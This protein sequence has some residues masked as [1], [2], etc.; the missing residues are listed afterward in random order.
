MW[1]VLSACSCLRSDGA[2]QRQLSQKRI[3]SC[4]P[5]RCLTRLLTPFPSLFHLVCFLQ[6]HQLYLVNFKSYQPVLT[7]FHNFTNLYVIHFKIP[8]ISHARDSWS[9]S[10]LSLLYLWYLRTFLLEIT[11]ANDQYF[12]PAHWPVVSSCLRCSLICHLQW[13]KYYFLNDT[14]SAISWLN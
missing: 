3:W 1:K 9:N 12:M 8:L 4:F 7:F 14:F 6:Y 13:L 5:Q 11:T 2:I 10:C